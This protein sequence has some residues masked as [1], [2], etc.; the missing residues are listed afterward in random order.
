MSACRGIATACS[1]IT[2]ATTS[3]ISA[4]S[5]APCRATAARTWPATMCVRGPRPSRTARARFSR[6]ARDP[7]PGTRASGGR[8]GARQGARH[9]RRLPAEGGAGA[10]DVAGDRPRRGDWRQESRPGQGDRTLRT[11]RGGHAADAG[12]GL[13]GAAA[14]D[15]GAIPRRRGAGPCPAPMPP[16]TSLR[17]WRAIPSLPPRRRRATPAG[18]ARDGRGTAC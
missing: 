8:E 13:A 6:S 15:A 4:S 12:E 18:G 16:A 1:S 9:V 14:S 10:D 3:P 5:R 2:A 17:R 11:R 7:V